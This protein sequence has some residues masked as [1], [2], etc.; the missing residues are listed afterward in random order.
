MF[1]RFS[2]GAR[3]VVKGAFAHAE[4]ERAESVDEGHMLLALLDG[5]GTRGSFALGALGAGTQERRTSMGRALAL[6]RRRAGLSRADA[7]ALAGLGVDVEEI[8]ARV[9]EA[10]GEGAL[11]GGR[12]V[13]GRRRTLTREAKGVLESSLRIALA[14]RDR[15]IGDEHL[16]L[17][18]AS[19][20]GVGAEVLAEHGVR[21]EGLERVLYGGGEAAAG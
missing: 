10:H 7:E 2:K 11:T 14:H 12:R 13:G 17:A 8:V 19:R 15:V 21:V 6:A 9:E 5:T 16:L 1:E 4:R 3:D 18:I 20:P